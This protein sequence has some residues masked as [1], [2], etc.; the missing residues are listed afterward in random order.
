VPK[1]GVLEFTQADV[2]TYKR[3]EDEYQVD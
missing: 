1:F 3:H 2:F